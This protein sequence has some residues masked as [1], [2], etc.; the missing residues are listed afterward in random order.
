[1]QLAAVGQTGQLVVIGEILDPPFG[2]LALGDILEADDEVAYAS[3]LILHRRYDFPLG[4]GMTIGVQTLGFALPAAQGIEL[5]TE[6]PQIGP[7]I[8]FQL[9]AEHG[10]AIKSGDLAKGV[11][12]PQDLES[13]VGDDDPLMGFKSNG[14]EAHLGI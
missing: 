9:Q 1:M 14:R 10:L 4:I 5:I 11:V 13:R 12:D 2:R 7:E 8:L 3:L 6:P